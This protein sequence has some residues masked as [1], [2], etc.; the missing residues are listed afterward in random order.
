MWLVSEVG[1]GRHISVYKMTNVLSN[2]ASFARTQLTVNAYT[3]TG[4][5]P[6]QDP[7]GVITNNTDSRI[8][9]AAES[10]NTLVATHAVSVS[11]TQDA[12]RWYIID[13]SSGTPILKDQGNVS[14]GN[15]T[16]AAYPSI[17]INSAG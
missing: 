5:V 13:V 14:L 10:N 16:Y 1:D 12:A 15:N 2:A 3:D 7:G 9:K 17:D 8:L 6:P 4:A 11:G